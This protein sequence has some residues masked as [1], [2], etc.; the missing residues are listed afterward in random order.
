MTDVLHKEANA[1]RSAFTLIE[2]LVV[3]A[4]IIIILA[5][6]FPAYHK[7]TAGNN[8]KQA[9]NGISSQVAAARSL[10]LA[11]QKQVGLLFF[12]DPSN[13]YQTRMAVI[14]EIQTTANGTE[15]GAVPEFRTIALPRF[16]KVA[17]LDV[18]SAAGS[19]ESEGGT[20]GAKLRVLLFDRKGQPVLRNRMLA[21]DADNAA[22]PRAANSNWGLAAAGDDATKFGTQT[23]FVVYDISEFNDANPP[24][25]SAAAQAT[26][27]MNYSDIVCVDRYTGTVMQIGK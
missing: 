25:T 14:Q 10:A 4:I 21:H 17:T 26:W 8:K 9:V 5:V 19:F 3:A 27:L 13:K 16:V 23:S 15:F 20:G 2:M 24:G 1:Q 22:N 6:S 11:S 18:T 7:L 12:E